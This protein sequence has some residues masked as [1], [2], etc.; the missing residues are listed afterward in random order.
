[1]LPSRVKGYFALA[2]H[3]LLKGKWLSSEFIV[4]CSSVW[5]LSFHLCRWHCKITRATRTITYTALN[6]R[7]WM[8]YVTGCAQNMMERFYTSVFAYHHGISNDFLPIYLFIYHQ[9]LEIFYW[10][11]GV[12]MITTPDNNSTLQV[13][14][15]L[16]FYNRSHG[17]YFA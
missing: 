14:H 5:T 17:P 8:F 6:I 3:I 9:S 2:I 10:V 15:S 16:K 1:M 4:L 7:L 12:V 11:C 13:L